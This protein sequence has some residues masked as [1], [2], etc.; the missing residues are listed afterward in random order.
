MALYRGNQKG[1]VERAIQYV[2]HRFFAALEWKDLAD[3]NRQAREW[4]L[5]EAAERRKP[6]DRS[7]TVKEAFEKEKEKLL[8]LPPEPYPTEERV[9]VSVGKAPYVTFDLNDYSVPHSLVRQTLVVV[10]TEEVVRVLDGNE[11]VAKHPRSYDKWMQVEDPLHLEALEEAK[12]EARRNR[13]MDRLHHAVPSSEAFFELVAQRNGNLGA[14]TT[15]L[16]HLLEAYGARDLQTAIDEVVAN[17]ASSLEDVR[18]V[19][20]VIR[21]RRGAPPAL[22]LHLPDDPRLQLD[23]TPHALESYDEFPTEETDE[24][25]SHR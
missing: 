3:L 7:M 16:I 11:V 12:Q 17:R 8:P 6:D 18:H 22:P 14:T 13:G 5:S 25:D 2:R 4:C 9:E 24:E 15:G 20:D 23:V 21:Q 10:A 1:R 19:L